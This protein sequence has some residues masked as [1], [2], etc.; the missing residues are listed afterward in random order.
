[1]RR[2]SAA[3]PPVASTVAAA[4]TGPASVSTPWQRS[5]SLHSA[6]AEVLSRTSIRG[7]AATIAASF[8][9]IS[10]PVWLPP[11][12]TMR[13]WVCPPSR[14]SASPPLVVEVEDD[15]ALAQLA[16]RARRL[17]DQRPHRRGAA[18]P[19]PRG[20]RVGGVLGGRVA[21][22]E[23]RGEAALG[24]E[25]G[26]LG[27]RRARDRRRRR[28]PARP[29][30]APSR[31]PPPRR[32]RRRRRTRA[33]RLSPLASRLIA[34]ICPRSQAAAASRARASTS[35]SCALGRG[36]APLGLLDPLLGRFGLRL[37]LGQAALGGG[38]RLLLRLALALAAPRRARGAARSRALR[39]GPARSFSRSASSALISAVA[40]SSAAAAASAAS[41]SRR[42]AAST[43]SPRPS[44]R[45]ALLLA[46]RVSIYYSGP[47]RSSTSR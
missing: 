7:S 2:Q 37:D 4:P 42:S 13:R 34:S 14:P 31:V 28:R 12:W 39:R 1:M 40:R 6:T 21:G 11:A 3:A 26:A 22:L 9:V 32:R 20:D 36:G 45:V 18:E 33:R 27:E 10:W 5:P 44:L 38:D 29:R 35:A 24:P 43:C 15:P 47:V 25:A 23:R 46:H 30:A 8:A 41:C 17:L 16:H 19:A